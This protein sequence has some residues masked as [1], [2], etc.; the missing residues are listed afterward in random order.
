MLDFYERKIKLRDT[1]RVS[2]S[3]VLNQTLSEKIKLIFK[4]SYLQMLTTSR[5]T[6]SKHVFIDRTILK[7]LAESN[8]EKQIF[9]D[10]KFYQT[11]LKD[12]LSMK[13]KTHFNRKKHIDSKKT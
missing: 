6:E 9:N 4:N 3:F 8:N 1:N 5:K 11:L 7:H 12:F 13:K 2:R 10:T